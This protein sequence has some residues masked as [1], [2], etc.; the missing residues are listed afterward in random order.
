MLPSSVGSPQVQWRTC[1]TALMCS[2]AHVYTHM[3]TL[4]PLLTDSSPVPFLL[5]I[6]LDIEGVSPPSASD[7]QRSSLHAAFF[8]QLFLKHQFCPSCSHPGLRLT[9][10][11]T[12]STNSHKQTFPH[13]LRC[14]NGEPPFP[15]LSRSCLSSFR[16]DFSGQ[17]LSIAKGWF[18]VS[19]EMQTRS[20]PSSS[21]NCY[22]P[23][24]LP[25]SIPAS[26]KVLAELSPG[27]NFH[28]S[29]LY[30]NLMS[31]SWEYKGISEKNSSERTW[32]QNHYRAHTSI[33]LFHRKKLRRR[34]NSTDKCATLSIMSWVLLKNYLLQG[35]KI[36][37]LGMKLQLKCFLNC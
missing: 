31:P 22:S 16:M 4:G 35:S 21:E 30:W 36:S 2:D 14:G 13:Q 9:D 33:F 20:G 25:T 6:F 27:S 23:P 7:L 26:R 29:D 32:K 34:L 19:R 37:N 17:S 1:M 11:F 28:H 8:S 3:Y 12:P 24:H 10:H 15:H 5:S 18:W